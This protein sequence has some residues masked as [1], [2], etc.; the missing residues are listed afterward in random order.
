MQNR[1]AKLSN[2]T[3]S[4]FQTTSQSNEALVLPAASPK[5][6][7]QNEMRQ[8][9]ALDSLLEDRYAK[10]FRLPAALR[11]PA[12]NPTHYDDLLQELEQAPGRSWFGGFMK[13]IRGSLRIS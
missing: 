13:R 3:A 10:Q 4:T 6:N 8:I 1:V 9:T 7:E 11:K 2:P 12:S 5:N